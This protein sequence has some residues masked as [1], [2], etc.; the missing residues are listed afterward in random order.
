MTPAIQVSDLGKKYRILAGQPRAGY[1]TL[2]E[3]LSRLAAAPLYSFRNG[4]AARRAE[5]FWAL[6]DINF[7]VQH[8][9]VLGVIGRN[10]AGKSTLLKILSQITK[11]TSGKVELRGRVGSLLEVGTGFHP[12]LTGRENVYLNGA[13]F[14]MKR[15]EIARKFDE[16][17]AFAEIDKFLDTP[18]KRYSSGMYIRL[19]FA[20]AAHLEPEILVVDE[21]LAVGDAQ[22]QEKCMGAMQR[23]ASGGRTILFVSH[24]M[25]AVQSLCTHVIWLD[26]GT[27]FVQGPSIEIVNRYLRTPKTE[28]QLN[29]SLENCDRRSDLPGLKVLHYSIL[30]RNGERM[31]HVAFGE[32]FTIRLTCSASTTVSGVLCAVN[33]FDQAGYLLNRAN[34]RTLNQP[35]FHFP[36]GDTIL[37]ITFS[38]TTLM[39][40]LYRVS[41]ALQ[42]GAHDYYDWLD[43][44]IEVHIRDTRPNPLRL[45]PGRA[46]G[47]IWLPVQFT[48]VHRQTNP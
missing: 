6:R 32:P 47:A 28:S 41:V 11:P 24:N 26:K 18:V 17:V 9:Q 25:S 5:E 10:G 46:N 19:A 23:T 36:Q 8:G 31:D 48:Q 45:I 27:I 34:N 3:T 42:D 7:D 4:K 33:W 22:F 35:D 40:G 13:I 20:V 21:V 44:A 12:E 30:D 38:S 29:G 15:S 2:R 37:D 16:I 43:Q 39:P 1:R 14:G